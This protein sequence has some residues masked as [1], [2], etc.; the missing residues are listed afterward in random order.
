MGEYACV[1]CLD[2][3]ECTT[4]Q[5]T[6]VCRHSFHTECL[7]QWVHLSCP[8]CRATWE[9]AHQYGFLVKGHALHAIMLIGVCTSAANIPYIQHTHMCASSSHVYA[10]IDATALM[11]GFIFVLSW[12][13]FACVAMWKTRDQSY[14]LHVHAVVTFLYVILAVLAV[15]CMY[16]EDISSWSPVCKDG[17]QTPTC[18]DELLQSPVHMVT[19]TWFV[20]AGVVQFTLHICLAYHA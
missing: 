5:T 20:I 4:F 2:T 8:I 11:V 1:I 3:R 17:Y 19:L 6:P 16:S 12:I 18:R 14:F 10:C 9:P 7:A 13:L 15:Q